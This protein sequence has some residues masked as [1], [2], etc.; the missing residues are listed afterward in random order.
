[1]KIASLVTL[2]LFALGTCNKESRT[3][4]KGEQIIID[5]VDAHGGERYFSAHFQFDF[6]NT[7]F[8]FENDKENFQYTRTFQKDGKEYYDRMNNLEFVRQIDGKES[9]L[10]E[11]KIDQAKESINSVIYFATLPY[12]LLDKA[13]HKKF[14]GEASIKGKDYKVIKV[15]FDQEGGGKDYDDT[16]H[17][18]INKENNVVDYLAYN[19]QVN[20][21]GVRFRVAYNPRIVGGILFQDYINYKAEV[22]TPL[23]EL[24]KLW[25]EGKLKELSKIET[26]NIKAL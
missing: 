4:T 23:I 25:E 16:Y 11:K 20:K 6:R 9:I 21:G 17:Y 24:P 26:E 12:K 3:P 8:T 22:G 14:I 13:V 1:M 7:R 2:L 5:A 15:T 19:Y 10:D 18:W